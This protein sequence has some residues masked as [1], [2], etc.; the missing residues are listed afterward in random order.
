MHVHKECVEPKVKHL[1]FASESL[2]VEELYLYVTT[3]R[4]GLRETQLGKCVRPPN[5][6]IDFGGED[7]CLVQSNDERR[8]CEGT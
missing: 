4:D 1:L 5:V 6:L 7:L 8:T 3:E 2:V